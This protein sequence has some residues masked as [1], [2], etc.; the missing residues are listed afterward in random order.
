[1][2]SLLIGVAALACVVFTGA[3]AF[4]QEVRVT[5]TDVQARSGQIMA[6]LQ[7]EGQFLRGRGAYNVSADPRAG[8][9]TLV[10]PDVAP[11]KYALVVMHDENSDRRMGAGANGMPTEGWAFSG[12]GLMGPPSFA[13]T[14]FDV[15]ASAPVAITTN[16]F[17]PYVPP[18]G[19]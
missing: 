11:G 18:A 12:P 15:G 13:G 8:T 14:S 19:Q 4:A 3:E 16:M 9:I 5:L 1:M 6:S 10:F 2:R 7:N 17:Y